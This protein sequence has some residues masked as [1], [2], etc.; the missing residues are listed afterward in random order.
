MWQLYSNFRWPI[1]KTSQCKR[2]RNQ[3]LFNRLCADCIKEIDDEFTLYF[4]DDEITQRPLTPLNHLNQATYVKMPSKC[5][6][7]NSLHFLYLWFMAS[8]NNTRK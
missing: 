5:D 3:F 4:F 2:P 6:I 1:C 7:P 8:M